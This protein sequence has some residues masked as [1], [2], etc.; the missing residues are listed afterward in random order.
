MTN[1]VETLPKYHWPITIQELVI[2]HE[3]KAL[4]DTLSESSSQSYAVLE[5]DS[6][7]K[8]KP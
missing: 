8:N 5:V 6:A 7:I 3:I 1:G 4:V 2:K